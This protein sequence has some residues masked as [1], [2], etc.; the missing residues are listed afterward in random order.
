MKKRFI[1]AILRAALA[2]LCGSYLGAAVAV[3][4]NGAFELDGNPQEQVLTG[5]SIQL[6]SAVTVH[7]HGCT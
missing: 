6:E 3:D 5:I 2:L 7:G 1:D 4:G